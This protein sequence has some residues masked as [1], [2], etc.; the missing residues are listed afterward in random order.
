MFTVLIVLASIIVLAI[1]IISIYTSVNSGASKFE[2]WIER[3]LGD[4]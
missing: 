2:E 3:I 1:T 4:K